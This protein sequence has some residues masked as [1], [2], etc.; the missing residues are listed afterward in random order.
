MQCEYITSTGQCSRE[1]VPPSR[2][3][4]QHSATSAQTVINQYRIANRVLGDA[5]ER[6]AAAEQLKD[7]R[8]EIVVLKS[9]LERRINI[10]ENDAELIA[11]TPA[12]KDLAAAIE[13]LT[14]SAHNMDVKLA[15][16][17]DKKTLMSLAQ[18]IIGIIEENIR[19]L[20]DTTPSNEK[21]DE[22]VEAIGMAIV[23]AI[24]AKENQ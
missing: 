10:A 19:P 5:P 22:T 15:N 21:V 4:E 7:L 20:V 23:Q 13:K 2:F 16:L 8:G 1:A 14:V 24:A 3:C 12:I 9:L 11:S 18:E 17:L 6:F